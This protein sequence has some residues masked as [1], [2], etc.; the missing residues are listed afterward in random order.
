MRI[1]NIFDMM[2]VESGSGPGS[3][4]YKGTWDANTNTPILS[5]SGGGG[6][7]GDYY[8]VNVAGTTLI[9]GENYWQV[10]DWIINNGL[11]WQKIDNTDFI[12][13][14][15]GETLGVYNAVYLGNDGKIYKASNDNLSKSQLLGI[16]I[17]S[18]IINDDI[19]IINEGTVVNS[20]WSWNL[21]LNKKVYLG[22]NGTLTQT[23]PSISNNV[24]VH[25]GNIES[26]DIIYFFSSGIRIII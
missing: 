8:I 22:I 15:A 20:S 18:G 7:K 25:C 23:I 12:V 1:R 10:G 6:V 5:S 4:I 24:I 16:T 17:N 14:K 3:V 26:S 9:D 19:K 21:T 11:I 13:K 2:F